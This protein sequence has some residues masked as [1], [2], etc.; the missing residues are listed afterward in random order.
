MISVVQVVLLLISTLGLAKLLFD[1]HWATARKISERNWFFYQSLGIAGVLGL[2]FGCSFVGRLTTYGE[3][4]SSAVAVVPFSL[5]SFWT[6]TYRGSVV[7][8][9]ATFLALL[10]AL[11]WL[12]SSSIS[13]ELGL[14]TRERYGHFDSGLDRLRLSVGICAGMIAGVYCRVLGWRVQVREGEDKRD[15]STRDLWILIMGIVLSIPLLLFLQH[16][17]RMQFA[18]L[19][20]PNFSIVCMACFYA[21]CI[22]AFLSITVCRFSNQWLIAA[23]VIIGALTAQYLLGEEL[24]RKLG[25]LQI[26]SVWYHFTPVFILAWWTTMFLLRRLDIAFQ[27]TGELL[28]F[29]FQI[30]HFVVATGLACFVLSS[31]KS[32]YVDQFP[33]LLQRD[34]QKA[35]GDADIVSN[36]IVG[37]RI[38]RDGVPDVLLKSLSHLR[39]LESVVIESS[40]PDQTF[41]DLLKKCPKLRSLVFRSS[42]LFSATPLDLSGFN[43]LDRLSF[44][45]TP[46]LPNDFA[47]LTSDSSVSHV[48]IDDIML[49]KHLPSESLKVLDL[50]MAGTSGPAVEIDDL[51]E[52]QAPELSLIRFPELQGKNAKFTSVPV[53]FPMLRELQFS[54]PELNENIVEKLNQLS[55][56]RLDLWDCKAGFER[57]AE[58][59]ANEVRVTSK[60]L[61]EDV[62]D[63]LLQEPKV[64]HICGWT[65]TNIVQA[66]LAAIV[67]EKEKRGLTVDLSTPE[68]IQMPFS[69]TKEYFD[70]GSN[71][72]PQQ[73]LRFIRSAAFRQQQLRS[74]EFRTRKRML[75]IAA[76]NLV[77]AG[78][79]RIEL[80]DFVSLCK[81]STEVNWMGPICDADEVVMKEFRRSADQPTDL[82]LTDITDARWRKLEPLITKDIRPCLERPRLSTD[83]WRKLA[84]AK[85]NI[86]VSWP[87]LPA[88]YEAIVDGLAQNEVEFYLARNLTVGESQVFERS[89]KHTFRVRHVYADDDFMPPRIAPASVAP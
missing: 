38:Q 7:L 44:T 42:T 12:L 53:N 37:I 85:E 30:K 74:M 19:F 58:L 84:K 34:L 49:L 33:Q 81:Q 69:Y 73:H 32:Q 75:L 24:Y 40:T 52:I 9:M 71:L 20:D 16:I 70:S 62:F 54:C 77:A 78:R 59:D 63:R 17:T 8:R 68:G 6:V 26:A 35:G 89:E 48:A 39:D 61:H 11:G 88:N 66:R 5:V 41:I 28:L 83:G 4:F 21:T 31:V 1:P 15:A 64:K 27:R 14:S 50:T 72:S 10:V 87:D 55:L 43:H 36:R 65:S 82:W 23:T 57:I 22:L 29:Q 67:D 18:R 2:A 76:S 46:V 45:D 51:L 79:I 60:N 25:F 86:V 13:S 47:R 56:V 3:L 80:G